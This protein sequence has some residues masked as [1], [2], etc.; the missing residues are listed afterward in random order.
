[1]VR[2]HCQGCLLLLPKVL[3]AWSHIAV[4]VAF[5]APTP[6]VVNTQALGPEWASCRWVSVDTNITG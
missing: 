4:L 6:M 2:C 1:M 5:T 3:L